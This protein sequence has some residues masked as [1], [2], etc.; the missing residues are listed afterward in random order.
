MS[1][2][3]SVWFTAMRPFSFTASIMPVLI[4]IAFVFGR[5]LSV[6]GWSALCFLLSAVCIHAGTNL[7]NDYYDFISG[8]DTKNKMGL[9]G[10]LTSGRLTPEQIRKAGWIMFGLGF[11]FGIYL[12]VR[13]GWPILILGLIGIFGGYAYTGKPFGYKYVKLGEIS[14]FIFMG[15]LL[16]AG[17]SFALTGLWMKDAFLVSLPVAFLVSA[18]LFVNNIRDLD[19][20]QNAG[21]KTLVGYLSFT[22]SKWVY[23]MMIIFPYLIVLGLAMLKII[24]WLGLSVFITIPLALGDI[25]QVLFCGRGSLS[26]LSSIV[27][28]TAQLHLVFCLLL[29]VALVIGRFI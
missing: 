13:L 1:S 20:D 28:K 15:I 29:S 17:V 11:L 9:S 2:K 7:I 26:D 16:V 4:G 5:G 6:D 12:I 27:E 21:L 8:V 19:T 25:K 23:V 3:L 22:P 18:I 10:A 14:V 24:P